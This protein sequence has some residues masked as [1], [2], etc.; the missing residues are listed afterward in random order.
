MGDNISTRSSAQNSPT[1][2]TITVN[3]IH[4][5]VGSFLGSVLKG[6]FGYI[7]GTRRPPVKGALLKKYFLFLNQNVCC[8]YSKEPSHRDGSFEHGKQ[9]FKLVDKKIL[10]SN[11]FAYLDL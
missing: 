3:W 8:G 7:I 1:E 9:K 6:T 4:V 2:E 11:C 5:K 10:R